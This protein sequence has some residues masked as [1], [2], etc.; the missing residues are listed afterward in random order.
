VIGFSENW[1]ALREPYDHAARATSVL[2]PLRHW[3]EARHGLAVVD[4]GAGSGSNLRAVAPSL[5]SGQS[6][7][8]VD[9]DADLLLAARRRLSRWATA[10]G[11]A[12]ESAARSLTIEGDGFSLSVAFQQADLRNLADLPLQAADLV[13]GAAL[14]DLVSQDWVTACAALCRQAALYFLLTFDGDLGF[15]P[16]DAGDARIRAAFLRHQCGDKGFGPALGPNAARRAPELLQAQGFAVQ[17]AA[18]PWDLGPE[19]QALQRALFDGYAAA[20]REIEPAAAAD[21]AA[22]LDRRR[23]HLEAGAQHRV[24]HRDL[25]AL[26][27]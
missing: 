8:L 12:L 18:S 16:E 9:Y 1:L 14:L 19:D 7:T 6:W 17:D 13:T 24:G 23:Q 10:E 27:A 2:A 15:L 11:F 25:L 4:L 21:I 5:G 3:R 26:P 22:W 20:A